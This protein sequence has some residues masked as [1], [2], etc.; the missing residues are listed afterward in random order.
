M[1]HYDENRLYKYKCEKEN[2]NCYLIIYEFPKNNLLKIFEYH[3]EIS[4]KRYEFSQW[5]NNENLKKALLE[6]REKTIIDKKMGKI[7]E[8]ILSEWNEITFTKEYDKYLDVTKNIKQKAEI[9]RYR[10]SDY[11]SELDLN[12]LY[13]IYSDN[14]IYEGNLYKLCQYIAQFAINE[15]EKRYFL[16]K[17]NNFP[18]SEQESRE[19]AAF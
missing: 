12:N 16:L 2:K 15:E 6:E 11:G 9:E 19:Y 7:N 8:Q 1:N 18:M 14:F 5:K 4:D 10:W 13:N 17:H 3:Y